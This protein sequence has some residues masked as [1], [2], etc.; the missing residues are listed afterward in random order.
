[1]YSEHDRLQKI[2]DLLHDA[3][4]G[5]SN[6]W[7]KFTLSTAYRNSIT[8]DDRC[9]KDF[10][11]GKSFRAAWAINHPKYCMLVKELEENKTYMIDL[12]KMLSG[13]EIMCKKYPRHKEDFL[14]DNED[15]ATADAFIQ[16]TIFG[17]IIYG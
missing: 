10:Y 6:Y 15:A 13:L 7:A 11:T 9:N 8:N 4:Y 16:C 12:D 2:K 1:M 14:N 17:E 5:G 3:C